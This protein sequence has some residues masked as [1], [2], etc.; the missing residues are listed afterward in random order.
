MDPTSVMERTV[1][2]ADMRRFG[3]VDLLL[4]VLVL[5]V[6]GGLRAGYLIRC[7][8]H[9]RSDGPLRVQ[10]R[11]P[12][13]TDIDA[14]EDMRGAPRPTEM[15]VLIYNVQHNHWF[16]SPAPFAPREEQ[17]AHVSPGYSW[18]V[19]TLARFVP[20]DRLDSIVRW[21]QMALGTL[22][23]GFYFLFARRGFRS[24]AV[25]TVAGLFA[26]LDPFSIIS[27]ATL[28]DGTLAS[29]ALAGCLF[30]AGHAGEK[31][32]ALTS[33]LFGL[34]LAGLALVRA[35]LLPFSFVTFVWFLLRSRSLP[36]GW[37]PALLAF[38][39]FITGLAPWMVR[40]Y[41]VFKEPVP[42]ASS[43]YL[44]LWIGNNS[45]ATGGPATPKML[46]SAP[47][48]ELRK[49]TSQ[50]KRY[51]SLG[52]LV[53]EEVRAHPAATL[54]RRIHAALAFFLGDR[55]LADGTLA[56][57]TSD[58]E[59]MTPEWLEQ[60]YPQTLQAVMLV[61]L[62]LAFLG[63]RWSYSWR[64]SS[65]PAALAMIWVPLPYILSHAE[66]L[67]GPRLPLD[68]VLLCFAAFA[69]VALIPKVNRPLLD[70]PASE[71]RATPAQP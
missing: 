62:C 58:S 12:I 31:G 14:P 44:H 35:A 30:L 28:A 43:A 64:W 11:S 66:G 6:A 49:I 25:S 23:A 50:P 57:P 67:S 29:F 40:N 60:I 56:E 45:E 9:S 39:G 2:M 15:D 48:P 37:L 70:P 38:L 27:T 46:E 61:M 34:S 10:D 32:G 17:T 22:T 4:L 13:L 1:L 8:D 47:G 19:G 41:Q 3:L 20:N 68:G 71:T 69:L 42:V 55:W 21:T 52:K 59:E 7:A 26:A 16:G 33:L 51:A 53:G 18:L 65:I 36:G 24:L 5:V 63:W 54:Q